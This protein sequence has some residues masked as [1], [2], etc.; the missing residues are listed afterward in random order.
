M[1]Y[2]YQTYN[3]RGGCHS[4]LKLVWQW[5]TL[6]VQ[7]YALAKDIMNFNK[8][9]KIIARDVQFWQRGRFINGSKYYFIGCISLGKYSAQRKVLYLL[10]QCVLFE[11][12]NHFKMTKRPRFTELFERGRNR[13]R[14][15]VAE[16]AGVKLATMLSSPLWACLY[17]PWCGPHR[18]MCLRTAPWSNSS[19]H[20]TLRPNT[21]LL[22]LST[23]LGLLLINPSQPPY[24]PLF[25]FFFRPVFF[26]LSS[27]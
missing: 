19:P 12:L 14:D 26:H 25:L 27:L 23:P 22:H 2:N 11:I 5:K 6:H 16:D 18:S 21:S 7:V 3:Y 20:T 4:T 17:C 10:N 8:V 24:I 1:C 13:D 9:N 15:T